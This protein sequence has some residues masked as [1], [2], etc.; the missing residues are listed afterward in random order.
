M[1]VAVDWDT[2]AVHVIAEPTPEIKKAARKIAIDVLGKMVAAE[3]WK[4]DRSALT[5]A[6]K[7]VIVDEAAGL[8]DFARELLKE[9]ITQ[10][11]DASVSRFF[12][13]DFD[14]L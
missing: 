11:V 13:R 1:T 7:N 3:I 9:K 8:K 12:E 4:T 2:Q 14:Y 6:V 5:N 10:K